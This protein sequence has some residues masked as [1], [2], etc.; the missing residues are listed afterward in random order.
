MKLKSMHSERAIR[1]DHYDIIPNI[2]NQS[3]ENRFIK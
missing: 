1:Y 2:F 3:N